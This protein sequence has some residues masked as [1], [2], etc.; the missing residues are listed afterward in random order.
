MLQACS[1]SSPPLSS[2]GVEAF[3]GTF[4][5]QWGDA[6]YALVSVP[7]FVALGLALVTLRLA[8]LQAPTPRTGRLRSFLLAGLALYAGYAAGNNLLA[9]ADIAA[10]FGWGGTTGVYLAVFALLS[11]AV[12]AL[13]V[14]AVRRWRSARSE[15]ER[16]VEG[17]TALALLVPLAFGLFDQALVLAGMP[18]FQLVGLWRLVGVA[19]IT[20]GLARRRLHD[21]PQRVRSGA[22]NAAGAAGAAAGGATVFG[23]LAVPTS[24]LTVPLLGGGVAAALGLKP[25][26]DGARRL[27][28]ADHDNPVEEADQL[29]EQRIETYRAA[30]E[31]AMARGTLDE[32]ET[33]L[34]NLRE[35]LDITDREDR[36]LRYYA[37]K[38][39]V[40]TRE[41]DADEAYERL[42]I[43]GEGG[44]GRTWLARDRARDRLV[45]LKEPLEQWHDELA[46]LEAARREARLAAKVRH[47]N[48]VEVEEVLEDEGRPVLVIE[49]VAGGSLGDKLREEGT[50]EPREAVRIVHDVAQGLTAVHEEGLVHRDLTPDNVLLTPDGRALLTDFGLARPQDGSGTQL[51]DG[52]A[53]TTGYKAP[54]AARGSDEPTVDVFGCAA[55]LH[56]CLYGS[57]PVQGTVQVE[58][59]VP[60]DLQSVIETGLA[61]DPDDRFEDAKTLAEALE[62]LVET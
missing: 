35:R 4:Y 47:P 34:S 20:Y 13:G 60:E 43:L 27:L 61:R 5:P 24:G 56:T 17:W 44:A 51:L 6:F 52:D 14:G 11:L 30:L 7:F 53:G 55:L 23:L 46:V 16:R 15:E 37:R 62:E 58:A 54:E 19:V 49:H 10:S 21:L 48:V 25:A 28:G 42:R 33:F 38:A 31:D 57:P 32:D 2:G 8:T 40:P 22:S 12:A 45:V 3:N 41:G 36:I 18:D 1:Q 50:L 9:Y 39:T 26:L 29:Y 59:N